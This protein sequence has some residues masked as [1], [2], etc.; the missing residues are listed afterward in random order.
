MGTIKKYIFIVCTTL[1]LLLGLAG[2]KKS[3]LDPQP[4]GRYSPEQLQSKKGI[5]GVLT[6]AYGM[7]DGQGIAGASGW[8]VGATSWV[9]G[10]VVSDDA[11]KG[12]DAGDQ[13]QMTE[14]EL[15]GSQPANTY[16]YYKWLSI[17]EGVARA[18]DVIR[19]TD[20][21]PELTDAEKTDYLAQARFLRGHFHFDAKRN[22]NKVPYISDTTTRYDNLTSIW[23]QIEADF[24][25][26]YDNL[27]ETQTLVGKANKWAAGAYLAKIYMF[28]NKFADAKALYD[29]I[30]PQGKT[31]NGKM[32]DL[33]PEY[34]KN[35]VPANENSEESVFSQQASASGIVVASAETSYELAYPYGGDFGCCGFYQPSHNLVNSYKLDANGLPFL[36]DSYNNTDLKNDQGL[37]SNDPFTNDNVTPLDTR[38]DW[39]VGRRGIPY[40]DWGPHP[41]RSWIRDQVYAG[42]YSPKKHV[43]QKSEVGGLTN[44]GSNHRQTAKNYNIIRFADVLLMAAEAEVE[45]G[46]LEKAR[47][48]VNRVRARAANP[49]SMVRDASG[50][51]SANYQT[52][53]YAVPFADQAMARNAVRF[54]RRLELAM[55]GHRFFDLVRWGVAAQVLNAYASK[56]K[57]KRT[58]KNTA[59]FTAGKN[60]YYPI[61]NRVIEIAKKGGNIL[62]Q[63][64]GY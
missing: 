62:E 38:L 8:M 35:W 17:Y 37:F 58:Y 7:L 16:F 57:L 47:E 63:N 60:E 21:I 30:I 56:E 52:K 33:Q 40:Y 25:F 3:F 36:D 11:Y 13:P 48:Y 29:V 28:Q 46:S 9:Y 54:E 39:S 51:P 20:K 5:E 64:P 23:P 14:I 34:W 45:I 12:T 59:V 50:N 15:W 18:N 19:L 2:C 61:S 1:S 55:E 26:A 31:S 24:K 41:G 49:G 32:Y 42:P 43:Y 44:G 10:D 53:S 4:F 22:F 6:G 27:P